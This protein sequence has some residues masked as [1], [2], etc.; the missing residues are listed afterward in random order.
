MM[1]MIAEFGKMGIVEEREGI[2]GDPDFPEVMLVESLPEE[3][4]RMLTAKAV[5]RIE[6]PRRR[7][8]LERAGWESPEQLEEFRQIRIRR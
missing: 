8:R 3:Q 6:R 1:Q 2:K 7:S 5:A 4:A